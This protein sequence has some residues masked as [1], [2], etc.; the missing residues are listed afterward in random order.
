MGHKAQS[1]ECDSQWNPEPGML[2]AKRIMSF[3]K[4][5]KLFEG[6][7]SF[8]VYKRSRFT[9]TERTSRFFKKL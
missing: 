4:I 2:E 9:K 5:S 8:L 1:G 3:P 6:T 7:L